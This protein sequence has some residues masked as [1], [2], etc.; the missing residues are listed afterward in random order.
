MEVKL[1]DTARPDYLRWRRSL[2]PD[3]AEGRRLVRQ[4]WTEFVNNLTAANGP[5]PESVPSAEHG[6]GWYWVAFPPC[7]LA[8]VRFYSTGGWFGWFGRRKAV[9]RRIVL[10]PGRID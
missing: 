7:Y 3:Q 4:F 1:H 8:L 9:V 2:S 10:S 6:R 5:P